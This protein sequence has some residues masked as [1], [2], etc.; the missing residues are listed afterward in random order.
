VLTL[1]VSFVVFA[2][3]AV[4]NAVET[5]RPIREI[6]SRELQ[7]ITLEK[8]IAVRGFLY[9]PN[10]LPEARL[11]VRFVDLDVLKNFE[12]VLPIQGG[13]GDESGRAANWR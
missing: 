1:P 8:G 7:D 3:A 12:V 4:S 5:A 11:V 6:P 10:P 9:F 13:T 2:I